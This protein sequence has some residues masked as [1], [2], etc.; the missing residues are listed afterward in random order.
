MAP[1]RACSTLCCLFVVVASEGGCGQSEEGEPGRY[2]ATNRPIINGTADTGQAHMAV[3]ALTYGP[4]SGAFCSGTLIAPNVVLT[5]AHCLENVQVQWVQVFFGNDVTQA[6]DYRGVSEMEPHW[7]FSGPSMEG[8]IGLIRLSANAP[9]S[10]TPIGALPVSQG[11]TSADVGVS[12][13]FSGFGVTE[14]SSDGVKLHVQTPID[15]VCNQATTCQGYIAPWSF[16]YG[17][18][19]GGPCSGDSGGPAFLW[20]GSVEYV[21]GVT[22][23]GDPTCTDFG[24]STMVDAYIDW[25]NDFIGISSED[26]ENGVDDDADGQVDCADPDCSLDAACQG[27]DAC[28]AAGTLTCGAFVSDTT[29][30][31]SSTF[32]SYSCL[33]Q[34]TEDGPERGYELAMSEGTQ[35]VATL[36]P[37][38]VGDLDLFLLPPAGAGCS[39]MSCID[40]SLSEDTQPETL[41]FTVPAGGAYLV[42][43]TYN[44][45]SAYT[46]AVTCAGQPELCGNGVDDDGDGDIDCGDPDCAADPAC[47][48]QPE[49]CDNGMDDDGDGAADC[50][51]PDCAA[52]PNCRPD[53]PDLAKGGCNCRQSNPAGSPLLPALL[54]LLLVLGL[55][56]RRR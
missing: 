7:T 50:G 43:E 42:V 52:A 23:Y 32:E 18:S 47:A 5:A 12:V 53:D 15:F 14:S 38:G 56:R 17:Q 36:T 8:D 28:E 16:E 11:L 44:T 29:V 39:P 49:L 31:G 40:A 41:S 55:V 22:S 10:V 26:C 35:V 48:G 46:L 24:V 30:G 2:I 4:G 6:G 3:V 51:D 20:R 45:P 9:S 13:D 33:S 34:S 19:T 54:P 27:P 1:H 21:A 25:I 37:T